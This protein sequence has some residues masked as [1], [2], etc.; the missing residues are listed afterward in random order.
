MALIHPVYAANMF[1]FTLQEHCHSNDMHS[2][3]TSLQHCEFK[4]SSL[5]D[6]N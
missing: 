4:K 2:F 1:N 6:S 5:C 3:E